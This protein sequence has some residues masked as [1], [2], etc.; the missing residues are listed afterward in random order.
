MSWIFREKPDGR[1]TAGYLVYLGAGLATAAALAALHHLVVA[2]GKPA[3][4]AARARSSNVAPITQSA[5]IMARVR[6]AAKSRAAEARSYRL[7]KGSAAGARPAAGA[8]APPAGFDPISA[9]LDDEARPPAPSAG[10]SL[11]GELPPAYP[12]ETGRRNPAAS[13][14]GSAPLLGY[15]DPT[16]D[17]PY[18][19]PAWPGAAAPSAPPADWVPRGTLIAVYL[20]TTVD[21]GNPAAVLQFG[22]ARN[23]IFNGRCQ[24]PFGTRFLG[25]LSSRAGRDRVNLTADTIL[26]PDGTERPVAASAVEADESGIRIRP[27]IGAYFYPPP[28]WVQMAPYFSEFFTGAMGLLASRAQQQFSIG[29]PGVSIASGSGGDLRAPLYQASAQA[30]QDLTQARLKELEQH[31]ASFYLVPAG[32][33]CWLQLDAD[34]NLDSDRG[35]PHAAPH[36]AQN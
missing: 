20:L 13:A 27:G 12:P 2:G 32:T 10:A 31:Y 7:E 30:V 34:L 25:K 28:S 19:A 33:A 8:E 24:L 14:A 21:T 4:R 36:H 3:P 1:R 22:A 17:I 18:D 26:Y 35:Q 6:V 16:A 29:V 5:A 23:V 11:F 15:R 9:A